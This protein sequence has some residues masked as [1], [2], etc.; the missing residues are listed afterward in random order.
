MLID[1]FDATTDGS[2][3]PQYDVGSAS[4]VGDE[5]CLNINVFTPNIDGKKRPVMV[6]LHGGAFV[7]GGGASYFFGPNYLIE[8]DVLLVTLNYRLGAF[9][10]L[11]TDDKAAGG[12]MALLDQIT[13][14]KWVKKHIEKFGGDPSQ[15]TIFGEDSGAAMASILLLSPLAEG[16]GQSPDFGFYSNTFF[17][18]PLSEKGCSPYYH[19]Y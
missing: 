8:H 5:D 19:D 17:L 7:M 13:A 9:G 14:L 18:F 11:A 16:N 3:C 12:N 4:A 10:F 1:E 15:V 2:V 6:Y